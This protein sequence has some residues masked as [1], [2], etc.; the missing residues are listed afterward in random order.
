[1]LYED[2]LDKIGHWLICVP[3]TRETEE[4]GWDFRTSGMNLVDIVPEPEG[5]VK[6]YLRKLVR[7]RVA[8]LERHWGDMDRVL[9]D[10][11]GLSLEN[12]SD[13]VYRSLMSCMG[14]G[15]APQDDYDSEIEDYKHNTG[16][17]FDPSPF[18]DEMYDI[19]EVGEWLAWRDFAP[20]EPWALPLGSVV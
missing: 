14:H 19:S 6:E 8:E 13:F 5:E 17:D 9:I 11:M 12:Q 15:I 7:Q 4:K 2:Q 10:G 20:G 3:Y 18:Y 16:R 1:M